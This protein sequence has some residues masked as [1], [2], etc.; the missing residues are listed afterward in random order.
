MN[1]F[2]QF[3][4]GRN[5][6]DQLNFFLLLL[7][8][9]TNILARFIV[10]AMLLNFSFVLLFLTMFRMLSRNIPK[11]QAENALFMQKT[12]GFWRRFPKLSRSFNSGYY[13]YQSAP[14]AKKD[15]KNFRY[16]KC[17]TCRQGLRA[18]KGKGKLKITCTKCRAV[19]YWQV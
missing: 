9:L 5:G 3:L 4:Q 18:P 6:N 11:R 15:R 12:A 7:S 1:F 16:F 13:G 2:T 10:G 17:P 8:L 14:K 19:F